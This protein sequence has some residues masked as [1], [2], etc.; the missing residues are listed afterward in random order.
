MASIGLIFDGA[1]GDA[2]VHLGVKDIAAAKSIGKAVATPARSPLPEVGDE[3]LRSQTF[4]VGRFEQTNSPG[5]AI[6]MFL[7]GSA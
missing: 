2:E 7:R 1:D 5:I 4:A 3:G 6:A